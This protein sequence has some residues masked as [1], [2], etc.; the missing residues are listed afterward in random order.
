MTRPSTGQDRSASLRDVHRRNAMRRL[1]DSPPQSGAGRQADGITNSGH[2]IE[3]RVRPPTGRAASGSLRRLAERGSRAVRRLA[4]RAVPALRRRTSIPRR[5][6]EQEHLVAVPGRVP[7][8]RRRVPRVRADHVVVADLAQVAR[9]VRR[10][11]AAPGRTTPPRASPPC[12]RSSA[13]SSRRSGPPS[14]ARCASGGTSSSAVIRKG[15]SGVEFVSPSPPSELV[16][17]AATIRPP[18]SQGS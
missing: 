7:R 3:P 9:V 6:V 10:S 14:R 1:G 4:T 12:T 13:R 8:Q 5:H 15:C 11:G 2:T 18:W 16:M 17:S